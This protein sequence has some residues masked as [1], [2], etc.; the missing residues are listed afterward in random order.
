MCFS[1][2][3]FMQKS[4]MNPT[5]ITLVSSNM[6]VRASASHIFTTSTSTCCGQQ[7]QESVHRLRTGKKKTNY[8]WHEGEQPQSFKPLSLLLSVRN[9]QPILSAPWMRVSAELM[10][11]CRCRWLSAARVSLCSAGWSPPPLPPL[12][13]GYTPD[14]SCAAHWLTYC[15]SECSIC[16]EN[17]DWWTLRLVCE[18]SCQSLVPF[19]GCVG[20]LEQL[21][22]LSELDQGY[23]WGLFSSERWQHL[24]N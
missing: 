3:P 10:K 8:P 15:P 14:S 22:Q 6:V 23:F 2:A 12:S 24:E 21:G 7:H 17:N 16:T 11:P 4:C 9:K 20:H 1:L 5:R 18:V 13:S 19:G